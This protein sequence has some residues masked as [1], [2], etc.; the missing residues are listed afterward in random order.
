MQAFA[1][2]GVGAEE[3]VFIS[4]SLYESGDQGLVEKD[5]EIAGYYFD[6]ADSYAQ[7][8]SSINDRL[9]QTVVLDVVA[10]NFDGNDEGREQILCVTGLKVLLSVREL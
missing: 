6:E 2:L 4:G 7:W 8:S 10:G 1:D 3:S 5:L 9:K